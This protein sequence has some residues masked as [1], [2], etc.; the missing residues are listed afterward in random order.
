M[1]KLKRPLLP[2]FLDLSFVSLD[3]CP[4]PEDFCGVGISDHFLT[5]RSQPSKIETPWPWKF[6][7][8]SPTN[9]SMLKTGPTVLASGGTCHGETSGDVVEA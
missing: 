4:I 8:T 3:P 6:I 7:A 9:R 1:E 5:Q 2:V